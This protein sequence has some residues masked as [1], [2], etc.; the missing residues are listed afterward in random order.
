MNEI[1]AIIPARGNS[2][3]LKNKNILKIGDKLL[4]EHVI[5]NVLDSKIFKKIFVSSDDNKVLNIAKNYPVISYKRPKKIA[6]DTS[7]V[8]DVCVDLLNKEMV[9]NG[10]LIVIYPTAIF[11]NSTIIRKAYKD[12]KSSDSNYLMGVGEYNYHPY[13]AL[14]KNK[15]GF[16]IPKWPR[17][18]DK[19]SQ[20]YDNLQVSNGSIYIANIKN[21]L[22][23]KTFYGENL[24]GFITKNIDINYMADYQKAK[25]I[26]E[27]KLIDKM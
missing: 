14:V 21:F 4:L 7:T 2:K 12:F 3:R 24:V 26:F 22:R 9:S 16:L 5:Q 20:F 23:E 17:L 18:N 27:N 11:I 8:V 13:Q 25:F 15:Y 1:I 6:R 19:Q 10:H